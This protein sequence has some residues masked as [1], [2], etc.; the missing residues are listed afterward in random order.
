M[1]DVPEGPVDAAPVGDVP[2]DVPTRLL[3]ATETRA[4]RRAAR[5]A[6][7]RAAR[8]S[9]PHDA[10][11]VPVPLVTVA[12]AVALAALVAV[13]ALTGQVP[14]GLA[15]GFAAVVLAYGWTRLF[16]AP[17]PGWGA[18]VVGAGG[19]AVALT[20]ALT[21]DEPLLRWVPASLGV[22]LVV[23]FLQQLLRRERA[24]LTLGLAAVVGGLSVVSMGVP[25]V[26][27]PFYARGSAHVVVAMTA[28][29]LAAL[30]ELLG[31]VGSVQR[32]LLLPVL[33]A[34][35]AGAAVTSLA[36][37][38]AAVLPATLL[39]VLVAGVSHVLRRVLAPLP[40]A[41]GLAARL[42]IGAASVLSVGVLVYLVTRL[43]VA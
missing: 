37:D 1:P 13:C 18:L 6:A 41:A 17:T 21:P 22:S 33:V 24:G 31:R 27:L 7:A 30:T 16:E 10:A 5:E 4:S 25:V 12:S 42:A 32:W 36:L 3:P 38:A 14:A 8:L 15:V 28:V 23:G 26:V 9:G 35:G 29:A 19:V 40:G 43:L 20:A 34:G 39:G 2:A 11:L